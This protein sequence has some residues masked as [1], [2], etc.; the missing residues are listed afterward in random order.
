MTIKKESAKMTEILTKNIFSVS[1]N[2][3]ISGTNGKRICFVVPS[4]QRG[5]RWTDSQINRLLMDLYDFGTEKDRGNTLVGDYYCLQ[6]IV[7]KKITG[8][9]VLSKLGSDYIIDYDTDYYEIVDGQQRMITVYI[10]LKYLLR[11]SDPYAIAFERDAEKKNARHL[12]LN[13]MHFAFDPDSIRSNYADEYY[14]LSAFRAIKKW[15]TDYRIK[16][17]K[18][19]LS[20]FMETVLCE[21]THVIWYELDADADCYSIFKNI[22]HGKIPLTDAELVKAMLL[23]S[24][25]YAVGA[26]VNA[27]IVKQE[28]DRYA[29]LWDEIQKSLSDEGMWSFITGGGNIDLPTNIDFIIRLI[30]TKDSQKAL[31]DS[32]Y[33]YFSYFENKLAEALD[34]KV[35]IESVF[36]SLKTTFRTI[37]DWYNNYLFHNY[38]GFILTYS[39]K[40]D[41]AT[42]IQIIIALMEQYEKLS[43]SSFIEKELKTDRIKAMFN[44]VNI[45]DINYEDNRKDVEKLLMLFNIEELNLL[46][47][48][49]DF[50]VLR[51]NKNVDD[52]TKDD[53]SIEHIKAQHSEITQAD[54]RRD[55]LQKEKESLLQLDSSTGNTDLKAKIAVIISQIDSLFTLPDIDEIE[56]KRIAELIDRDIDNFDTDDM[57]KLGNLAL[58]LKS[59]NSSLGNKPFYQKREQMNEWL[60]NFSKNI[61]NSTKKVF[62]KMYSPQE[63]ALDFTRWRKSDFNNLFERQK[64]MLEFFIQGC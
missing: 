21:K 28:Q 33:K 24:K 23:N 17:G 57:H 22:N 39:S 56:F 15:F 19:N 31:D 36:E 55:Y 14:F 61:P 7:V 37:Q 40:K 1:I 8:S 35:Y 13:S 63:Y 59:D 52:E 29:R 41:V 60:N 25:Y 47:K 26:S 51:E 64:E 44:K 48:K 6:P 62:L 42:R 46:H 43:K 11:E 10:L 34:K 58:L 2:T 16:T 30:V 12:L 27:K 18:N 3:L 53:W 54:K 45:N 20:S 5:Y 49:F 4:Y 9:E 38:I 32:D 50:C